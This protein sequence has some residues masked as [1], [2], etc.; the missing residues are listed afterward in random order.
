M[1]RAFSPP[2][3]AVCFAVVVIIVPEQHSQP[4]L[5][6]YSSVSACF[7]ISPK[8]TSPSHHAQ[9]LLIGRVEG[10]HPLVY[11]IF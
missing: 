10:G 3:S 4:F 2:F 6:L 5:S 1:S 11:V 8:G 7:S 9:S